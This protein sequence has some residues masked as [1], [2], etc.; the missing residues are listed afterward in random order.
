MNETNLEKLMQH[1]KDNPYEIHK[2]S[3]SRCGI[4]SFEGEAALAFSA[5]KTKFKTYNRLIVDGPKGD[6]HDIPGTLL[7]SQ[8][9]EGNLVAVCSQ[10]NGEIIDMQSELH[11]SWVE[12]GTYLMSVKHTL[13]KEELIEKILENVLTIYNAPEPA[14]YSFT[15]EFVQRIEKEGLKRVLIRKGEEFLIKSKMKKEETIVY[16]G[17][18]GIIYSVYFRPNKSV[19]E[20]DLRLLG[21]CSPDKVKDI[22]RIILKISLEWDI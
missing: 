14:K 6:Y 20:T 13:T 19:Q 8:M 12:S 7:Y 17:E 4:V 21:I 9:R 3:T 18:E 11:D 5:G 2:L 1:Y 10:I 22:D 16:D 15:T